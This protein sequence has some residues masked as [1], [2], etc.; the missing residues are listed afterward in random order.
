M[1]IKLHT[2]IFPKRQQ[3]LF[4]LLSEQDWISPFYFEVSKIQNASGL[5]A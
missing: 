1:S 4:D 5:P 2:E 3:L